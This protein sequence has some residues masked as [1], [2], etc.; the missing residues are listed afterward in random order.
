[1][2]IFIYRL[3]AMVAPMGGRRRRREKQVDATADAAPCREKRRLIELCM[4]IGSCLGVD[5]GCTNLIGGQDH[6]QI[7]T[8]LAIL[9]RHSPMC[10][11]RF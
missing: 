3:A 4:F 2:G 9:L 7:I 6:K 5:A 1:M 8:M 10:Q 11:G